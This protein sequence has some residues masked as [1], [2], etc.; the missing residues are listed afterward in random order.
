MKRLVPA[1]A[2]VLLALG[3]RY[4]YAAEPNLRTPE[5]RALRG[6]YEASRAAIAAKRRT[7]LRTMLERH[8]T[9]QQ[10]KQRQARI[11][12]NTTLQAD[13][14]QAV[15]LFERALDSLESEDTF[16]FPAKVRPT[17]ERI[18]AFC[19]RALAT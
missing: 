16:I 15:M 19:T 13:T 3:T 11:L 5:I 10:R 9:E 17:L 1:L 12:G 2:V 6:E 4:L 18:T 8:L 14:S 7:E